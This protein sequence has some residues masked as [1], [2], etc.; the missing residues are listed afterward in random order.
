MRDKKKALNWQ[1]YVILGESKVD[2]TK[3]NSIAIVGCIV[4]LCTFGGGLVGYFASFDKRLGVI[5]YKVD[6]VIATQ[7][8]NAATIDQL[9]LRSIK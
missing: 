6:S 1:R 5:E 3:F 2:Q 8:E 9:R 4:A 7:K